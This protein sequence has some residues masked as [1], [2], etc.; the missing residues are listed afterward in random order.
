MANNFART[1]Y[2]FAGWSEDSNATVN[3]D[4]KIYGPNEAI[5]GGEITFD[6]DREATLYAVWVP[7]STTMTRQNFSCS[8]LGSLEVIALEDVRDHNVYT[9]G[10]MQDGVCWMM[11]NLR[12]GAY[13]SDDEANSQDFGGNFVGLANSEDTN[14]KN[15]NL[16]I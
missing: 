12:L 14:F 6:S 1:N 15:T 8:S 3:S 11:E 16:K 10:M 9:V 4:D 2:G 5:P 13:G 7:K